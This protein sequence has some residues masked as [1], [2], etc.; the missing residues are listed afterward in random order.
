[1]STSEIHRREKQDKP[2]ARTEDDRAESERDALINGLSAEVTRVYD[3]LD[4][5]EDKL[6][7][8]ALALKK[9]GAELRALKRSVDKS[10]ATHMPPGLN[11]GHGD[12]GD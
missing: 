1:M 11:N 8:F 5:C 6:V 3:K 7:T 2:G 12:D 10:N 9:I 4:A